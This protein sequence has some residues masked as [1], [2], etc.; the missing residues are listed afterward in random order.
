MSN[1]AVTASDIALYR[2]YDGDLD[3]LSR[4]AD[5]DADVSDA[6]WRVIDDLRQRA[7]IVATGR[8]SQ[9]FTQ[10]FEADLAACIPD[11][12]VRGEFQQLVEAD[13]KVAAH[14]EGP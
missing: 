1:I 7:F 14:R 3:G 5:R 2:R 13:L 8:G 11:V 4:S 9:T 12:Q 6:A 10:R